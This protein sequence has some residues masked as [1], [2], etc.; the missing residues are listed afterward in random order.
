MTN[1]GP[2][3][4]LLLVGGGHAHLHVLLS[5]AADP[6][7]GA[8][9]TLISPESY[10]TYS[11]M[12]PGVL[13]GLYDLAAAQVDLRALC[14]RAG[15]RFAEGLGFRPADEV[16]VALPDRVRGKELVVLVLRPPQQL[17]GDKSRHLMEVAV[18][19]CPNLL[20][21]LGPLLED[22]EAVHGNVHRVLLLSGSKPW[23][24][25]CV[26]AS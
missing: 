14:A 21:V 12:M 2:R 1:A 26:P 10:A 15:V 17:E 13:A 25:S 4:H 5:L 7:P 8:A 11:G 16:L 9:V 24:G 6:M 23:K 20:E 18:A 3:R 19:V 22:A